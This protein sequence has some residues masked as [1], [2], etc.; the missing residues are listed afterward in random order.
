MKE[1]TESGLNRGGGEVVHKQKEVPR[2]HPSDAPLVMLTK[3]QAK[4]CGG[5]TGAAGAKK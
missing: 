4:K 1:E 3:Q 2:Y 5:Q